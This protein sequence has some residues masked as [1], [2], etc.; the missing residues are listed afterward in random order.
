[1][2]KSHKKQELTMRVIPRFLLELS[3]RDSGSKRLKQ[4][5]RGKPSDMALAEAVQAGSM[6]IMYVPQNG[7][8][9]PTTYFRCLSLDSVKARSK[10]KVTRSSSRSSPRLR[11]NPSPE[12]FPLQDTAQVRPNNQE[13]CRLL[14]IQS[15]IPLSPTSLPPAMSCFRRAKSIARAM[16]HTSRHLKMISNRPILLSQQVLHTSRS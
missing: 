12:F 1:M 3:S 10:L 2:P 16:A 6:S 9:L 5:G 15:S 14:T 8:L 4:R 7:S 13:R 11:S